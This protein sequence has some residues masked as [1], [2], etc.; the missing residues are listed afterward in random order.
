MA[1]LFNQGVQILPNPRAE[2]RKNGTHTKCRRL[3][4]RLRH[5]QP[6]RFVALE[7][8]E[9]A[10]SFHPGQEVLRCATRAEKTKPKR[11]TTTGRH[12]SVTL[13]RS[14]VC[15]DL[16]I[17]RIPASMFYCGEDPMHGDRLP[18]AEIWGSECKHVNALTRAE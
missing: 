18:V 4:R 17:E 10:T 9:N 15:V 7:R 8:I 5:S 1:M 2:S 14:V 6:L 12:C 16:V 3:A 13:K 11:I